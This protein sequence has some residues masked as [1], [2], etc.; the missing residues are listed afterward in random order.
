[1]QI[2]GKV[3]KTINLLRWGKNIIEAAFCETQPVYNSCQNQ[4]CAAHGQ[5]AK[6]GPWA[7][8]LWPAERFTFFKANITV[9][10][11]YCQSSVGGQR[12]V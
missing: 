2:A 6:I 12:V 7:D 3:R 1:M 8:V 9:F 4:R 11:G 5:R 10:K